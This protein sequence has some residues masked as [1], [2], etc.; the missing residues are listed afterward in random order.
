MNTRVTSP[1]SLR[2]Q[3]GGLFSLSITDDHG[4]YV[5]AGLS[6]TVPN[7]LVGVGAL[8]VENDTCGGMLTV[9]LARS[10]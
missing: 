4:D 1:P 7:G 5:F 6:F 2:Y 10:R 9:F 8:Q 3:D